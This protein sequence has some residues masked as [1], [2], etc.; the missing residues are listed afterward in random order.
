MSQTP[1]TPVENTP[2]NADPRT[3]AAMRLAKRQAHPLGKAAEFLS[4]PNVLSEI[5]YA[6]RMMSHPESDYATV[7]RMACYLEHLAKIVAARTAADLNA[8]YLATR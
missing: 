8:F 7:L 1:A 6:E 3:V 2:A 5:R 4:V